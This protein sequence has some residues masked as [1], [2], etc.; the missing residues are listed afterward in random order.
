MSKGVDLI[1]HHFGASEMHVSDA[2]KLTLFR[3]VCICS[4]T[5]VHMKPH[6]FREF[7]LGKMKSRARPQGNVTEQIQ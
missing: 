6:E 2:V 7:G 3:C 1:K 5:D 4:S